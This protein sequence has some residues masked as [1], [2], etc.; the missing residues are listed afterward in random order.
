MQLSCESGA[1]LSVVLLIFIAMV[2]AGR[3]CEN[4]LLMDVCAEDQ[5]TELP[6]G[7]TCE[8]Q[9]EPVSSVVKCVVTERTH[10]LE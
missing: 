6:C 3:G 4:E 8:D 9:L 10:A 2:P 7:E 5:C 1:M